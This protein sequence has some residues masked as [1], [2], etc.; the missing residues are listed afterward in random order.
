MSQEIFVRGV[1]RRKTRVDANESMG[2][3]AA[4][5]DLEDGPTRRIFSNKSSTVVVLPDV[6]ATLQ[7]AGTVAAATT[8]TGLVFRAP[9]DMKVWG[10]AAQVG[11]EPAGTA[12]LTLDVHKAAT[13]TAA[14]TTI[15][16]D[17]AR[18]PSFV[19][20][21]SATV[22][23]GSANMGYPGTA[24]AVTADVAGGEYLRVEV[25]SVGNST[26]GADLTVQIFGY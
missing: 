14:G 6:V 13:P 2:T 21:E 11:T 5:V 26:A 3:A 16:T 25:D 9:R 20:A 8:D 23:G 4:T 15:F 18:R 10:V 17:Q 1:T 24:A 12:L 22:L 7:K 19:A